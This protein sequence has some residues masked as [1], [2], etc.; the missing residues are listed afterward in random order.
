MPRGTRLT[1]PV[2][3]GAAKS[4]PIWVSLKR[5]VPVVT[6]CVTRAELM[7]QAE[8]QTPNAIVLALKAMYAR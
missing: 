1:A 5:K 8:K 7:T 4:Q 6:R 3:M 2:S